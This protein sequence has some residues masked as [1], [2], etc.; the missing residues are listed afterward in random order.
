MTVKTESGVDKFCRTC[1]KSLCENC[2][3]RHRRERDD[4][5][6]V[7]RTGEVIRE[8]ELSIILRP[9]PIHQEYNAEEFCNECGVPICIKCAEEKHTKHTTFAIGKKYIEC[10]NKLNDL[11]RSIETDVLPT[12]ASDV[13]KLTKTL[14]AQEQILQNVEKEVNA[15]RERLKTKVDERCDEII[16]ELRQKYTKQTSDMND[17]ITDLERQIKDSELFISICNEKVR[18]GG[19][20]LIEYSKFTPPTFYTLPSNISYTIPTFDQSQNLLDHI[21]Q[22]VGNLKWED[23][24]ITL[25]NPLKP[26]IPKSKDLKSMIAIKLLGS[27]RTEVFASSVVPTGKGTVWVAN[28]H[29]DTMKMYDNTGKSIRSV[30]VTKAAGIL[31]LAVKQSGNIVVCNDDYKVRLVTVND[32]VNSLIDTEPFIP[33]GICLTER[34]EIVVCMAGQ[35]DENRVA[36]YS[37]DGKKLVRKIVVKD[38]KGT[39][40]LTDPKR[41]VM[42]GEY[43]SVMN[44]MSNVVTCDEDGKVT[45]VYD[46][47]QTKVGKLYATGMCVDKFC[48]LLISD[49]KNDCVHFVDREGGLIK[50]LLT[51]KQHRIWAP[52]GIGV[53]DETGTVWVGDRN[54]NSKV[55]MFGY[56]QN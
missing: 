1:P 46:G 15:F 7:P 6:I 10:E 18:E 33:Q 27:F 40:L 32:M 56:E 3:K 9:C 12:L 48:N 21:T 23:Y 41:V 11:V 43:I 13:E 53:D 54:I 30:T 20:D 24:K 2:A 14:D 28:L 49:M 44:H 17:M 4:H 35:G 38:D 47:S 16:D 55:W 37:P 39:Q 51:N 19:L 50:I 22:L 26:Q 31:D 8:S 29:S 34:E 25:T 42:N 52:K 36:V 5:N 45:W